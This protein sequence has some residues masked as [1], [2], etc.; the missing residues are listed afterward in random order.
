[1]WFDATLKHLIE[2]YP[3]DWLHLLHVQPEGDV[4]VIDSDLSTVTALADKVIRVEESEPWLLQIEAQSSYD[5]S[6]PERMHLYSTLLSKRHDLPVRSVA[7]LLRSVADGRAMFGTWSRA[8]PRTCRYIE[9]WYDVVRVWELTGDSLL[10]GG[11]GVLPL[12]VVT[13]DADA[14]RLPSIMQG[15]RQAALAIGGPQSAREVLAAE[16]VL[17]GLRYSGSLSKHCFRRFAK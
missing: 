5:P 8:H 13:D 16:Y 3:L 7:L 14:A 2:Q 10:G 15:S 17:L 11:I 6:L 4:S 12:T 1:M 9:F